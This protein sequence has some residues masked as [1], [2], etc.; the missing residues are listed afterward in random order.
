MK[1]KLSGKKTWQ[2]EIVAKMKNITAK[3]WKQIMEENC[4]F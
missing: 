1:Q 4:L 2:K 3:I